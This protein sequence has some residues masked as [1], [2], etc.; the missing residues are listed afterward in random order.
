[1]I[2]GRDKDDA[3]AR[4]QAQILREFQEASRTVEAAR[5]LLAETNDFTA[6]AEAQYE[7]AKRAMRR[8][9]EG[10]I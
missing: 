2:F 3:K 5:N 1:M 7:T 8:V 9:A 6:R 10:S 4:H